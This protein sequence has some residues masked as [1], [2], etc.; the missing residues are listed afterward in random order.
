MT[1]ITGSLWAKYRWGHWW[2][3]SERQLVLFLVLFLFY[4]AYFML[5]YSVEPGPQ[6]AN[7]CAVYAIFGV[8]LI[9]ISFLAIRLANEYIHPVAFNR[10]RAADGRPRSS[11]RSA[12]AWRRCSRSSSRS[13]SSS[14]AGKR[15]D[16]KLRE[17]RELLDDDAPMSEKV[18]RRRVPRRLRVVLVYLVIMALKLS[19]L[20][21]EVG[22][23]TELA[24]K[25]PRW[26]SSSSGRRC[27]PTAR[28][29]LPTQATRA[30]PASPDGSRPGAC[31]SA[32]CSR[33]RCSSS[34]RRAPRLPVDDW[35]GSL[36]L[37]VW[38][39]VSVYL[40]WGCRTRYRLLGLAVM[41]LAVA[42][43]VLALARRRDR[44]RARTAATRPC[45][46]S[47]T[48]A[49][50]L[51]AFA[52]FTLAA[53]L[54][55]LYLWQER[56]LKQ[57]RPASVLGRAPSL[58]TL[59][60]LAAPDDRRRA[61]GAD[62]RDRRRARPAPPRRR[63][64][65][66]ADGGHARHLGDLRRVPR[67]ALGAAAAR[68]YLALAGFAARR[69]RP[70]RPPGDPLLV[71]TSSASPTRARPLA[72]RERAFVPLER[73]ARARRGARR[74]RRGRLPLDLQP[75]RALPR[76]RRRRAP[77]ARRARRAQRPRRGRAARRRLPARRRGGGAAP[78]PRR[79]RARL[80]GARRGR[81]PRPGAHRLRGRHDR[82]G[83]RPRLP[84]G[85][86]RGEEGARGDGD[87]ARARRRSRRRRRRSRSRSSGS[88]R[89]AGCS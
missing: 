50:S 26:L 86:P 33:P 36:N 18:R 84:A 71:M 1:L 82:A 23:L 14:C 16:A 4:S 22:E 70:P 83:A 48:S 57:H 62:G 7:L 9:P 32:G 56:R 78:L 5:R 35:A 13:T 40:V 17:L 24:R 52:A 55:A 54:S 81:D 69:R 74:R 21:R 66:R 27:S 3:W 61:A 51:F 12:S 41:P 43:L 68:A 58:L 42:L 29:L 45:S 2:L 75:H 34:G 60:S 49:C 67:P 30:I 79:R 25:R 47:S 63:L 11:P 65:R 20:E 46:S 8:I 37:F 53:A 38:L 39:V 31:G 87:R 28:R 76:R 19:R 89:A 77:R 10:P 85:A 15:L 73:A 6:R 64:G 72:V 88:W 44:R 80:D 59:E